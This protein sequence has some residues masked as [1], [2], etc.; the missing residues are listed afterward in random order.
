MLNLPQFFQALVEVGE[1]VFTTLGKPEINLEPWDVMK[2]SPSLL[3]CQMNGFACG[4]FIHA[5]QVIRNGESV[6][7]VTNDQT[8]KV[9][10]ETLDLIEDNLPY[11]YFSLKSQFLIRLL[12]YYV[13][14]QNQQHRQTMS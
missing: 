6:S 13:S 8:A 12:D 10:S 3:Q 4:F 1:T 11:V 5:I 9:K 14:S 7:S 2:H